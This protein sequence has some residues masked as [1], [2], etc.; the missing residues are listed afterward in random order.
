MLNRSFLCLFL[1]LVCYVHW[2]KAESIF[3]INSLPRVLDYRWLRVK[4]TWKYEVYKNTIMKFPKS[5]KFLFPQTLLRDPFPHCFSVSRHVWFLGFSC[6]SDLC[7]STDFFSD[8]LTSPFQRIF[9]LKL[10]LSP[11]FFP[12]SFVL[13]FTRLDY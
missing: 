7:T 1:V 5:W 12:L 4:Y 8:S 3:S 13:C 6:S 10:F 11:H 2:A 9:F